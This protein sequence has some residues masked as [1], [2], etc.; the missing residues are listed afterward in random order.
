MCQA[1][2]YP[3]RMDRWP[4]INISQPDGPGEAMSLDYFG[5][6]PTT[7]SGN[8]YILLITDRFSRRSAMYS[9][10]ASEFSAL[11][12]ANSLVNDYPN[13]GLPEVVADG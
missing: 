11:G 13:M 12:T 4:V 3:R 8:K 7:S 2:K 6:L 1:R 9:V 5:P 10:S